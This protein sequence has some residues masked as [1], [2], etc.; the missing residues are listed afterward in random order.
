MI[1]SL[2][3]CSFGIKIL[4]G[5]PRPSDVKVNT[6]NVQA[7]TS[8]NEDTSSTDTKETGKHS[9][10]T[11]SNNSSTSN[12]TSS[13]NNNSTSSST[14]SSS[15]Q[16]AHLSYLNNGVFS[17]VS[18]K[19][20][21]VPKNLQLLKTSAADP[22]YTAHK[23]TSSVISYTLDGT[24][25]QWITENDLLYVITV[26]RNTLAVIDTHTMLPLYNIT[27][28]SAPAEIN[29]FGEY[30]YISFPDL[31][32]I[33]ILSKTDCSTVGS[34]SFECEVSSFYI[35]GNYIY[36]S[37][38]DQWCQVFRKNLI[39]NEVTM[40]LGG[41]NNSFYYPKI[42][43]NEKDNILYIGESKSTGCSLYYYNA[44]TL[45]LKNEF[46]KNGYGI[47]NNTRELFHVNDAVFWSYYKISD[48]NS[49]QLISTYG[50]TVASSVTFATTDYVSTHEGVFLADTGEL[51]VSCKDTNFYYDYLLITKSNNVFFRSEY[52]NENVI[53]GI[54][55]TVQ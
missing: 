34:W 6:D 28:P 52:T 20:Q 21:S 35:S 51:I 37:E 46:T 14:S 50:Q 45:E 4:V 22:K 48:T 54:N 11:S 7:S 15:N 36:Y 18:A 49:S 38:H 30:I 40:I 31:Y 43:L 27:L 33:D 9:S 24:I 3:S 17:S 23:V 16:I 32:R 13:S 44:T 2:T 5:N 1:F 53:Y 10:S 55:Y 12:S 26:A 8:K 42:Y 19:S 39:T 29:I 41:T 47:S 25:V